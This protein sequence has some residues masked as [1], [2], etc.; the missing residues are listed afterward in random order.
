MQGKLDNKDI[1]I[2]TY[3]QEN[4]RDKI[5]EISS[6]LGIPRATVFER[7]ERLKKEGYIQKYTVDLDYEKLGYSIMAYILIAYDYKSM[8]S[9][10][11]LCQNLC[12]MDNILSASIIAGDWDVIVLTVTRNMKELSDLVL[13][14]L[15]GMEGIAKTLSVP[16]FDHMK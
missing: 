13:G 9:Q 11:E 3:L 14:K 10:R 12:K 2:L 4:G 5:S 16:V 6:K 7:M 15:K 8:V 1:Q